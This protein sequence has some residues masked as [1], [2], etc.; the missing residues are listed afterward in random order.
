M[1][2]RSLTKEQEAFLV[3]HILGR[4][5]QDL[6][7]LINEE[8]SINWNRLQVKN[9]KQN[10][11]LG[12]SGLT[13]YYTI[14]STP[15]NK[16]KKGEY[17]PGCEKGWFQ[18]GRTPTNHKPIGSERIDSKDGYTLIKTAEPGTWEL[19]HKVLWEEMQGKIFQ[20][21]LDHWE[22]YEFKGECSGHDRYS[23]GHNLYM[24][25]TK[26]TGKYE[27]YEVVIEWPEVKRFIKKMLNPDI[28][29]RQ[30]TLFELLIEEAR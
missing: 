2:K 10:H 21:A 14:G 15:Q 8:F 9:Y 25:R 12:S 1:S 28:E 27:F 17:F 11:K 5:N 30:I 3:A 4:G 26:V 18:K 19:K 29:G 13:G 6:A 22:T 16:G 24:D 7:D 23:V 20:Y